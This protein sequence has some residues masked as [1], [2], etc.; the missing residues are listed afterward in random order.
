MV[1]GKIMEWLTPEEWEGYLGFMGYA[2]VH[3]ALDTSGV[4]KLAE[5]LASTRASERRKQALLEEAQ[6]FIQDD[7][8]GMPFDADQVKELENRGKKIYKAI[9]AEQAGEEGVNGV[10]AV[11]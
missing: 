8:S 2:C 6:Q 11:P 1:A 4:V 10:E 3:K 7:I 9:A 5:S